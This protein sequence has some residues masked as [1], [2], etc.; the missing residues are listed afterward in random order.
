LLWFTGATS[1]AALDF[2][3]HDAV[4][5]RMDAP[6]KLAAITALVNRLFATGNLRQDSVNAVIEAITHREELGSTGIGRGLAIPH[7]KHPSVSHVTGAIG[8]SP[9]GIDFNSLDRRPVHT[10]ILFLSPADEPGEHLRAL[11]KISRL[12]GRPR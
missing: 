1:R 9:S 11:E 7:T 2:V 12:A 4:I 6:D 3:P 5:S 10:V 8:Y